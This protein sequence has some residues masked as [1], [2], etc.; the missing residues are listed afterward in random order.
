MLFLSEFCLE[1]YLCELLITEFDQFSNLP[2]ICRWHT[3]AYTKTV[4]RDVLIFKFLQTCKFNCS[5]EREAVPL[6]ANNCSV[7]WTVTAV[8]SSVVALCVNTF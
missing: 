4:N 6:L 5:S 2:T 7:F 1:F 3:V 8:C